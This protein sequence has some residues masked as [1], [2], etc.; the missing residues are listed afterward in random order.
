MGANAATSV[1]GYVSGEVLTAARLNVTNSGAPVFADT[2]ARDAAFGGTGEKTL[3]EG[4]LCYL[5][6]SNVVQYY[7]GS[8][9]ATVGPSTSAVVQVKSTTKDDTFTSASTSYVDVTGVSVSITP[10]SASNNVLVVLTL[11]ACNDVGTSALNFRLDRG[12]TAIGIGASAG[13]RDRV[14][15]NVNVSNT[16]SMAARTIVYLDSPA[17]TSATTYKL[18][19]R[20][21]GAGTLYV[22]RAEVD[23]DA[24]T[25]ARGISTITVYEVTP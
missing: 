15:G 7:D 17:T 4:Q 19:A 12:G 24:A 14:S 22:N 23:T 25:T 6:D 13:S 16:A 1:P 5:E 8:S 3:A 11:N 9:W 18:Q 21:T 2:S 20:N 10:T